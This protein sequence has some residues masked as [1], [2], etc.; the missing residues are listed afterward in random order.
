MI[1]FYLFALFA[2]SVFHVLYK[3][4]LSFLLLAFVIALPFVF[5]IILAI[6][7][8][9]LKISVFCESPV[10][11]RGKAAAVKVKFHNRSFIPFAECII[12]LTY[13]VSALS[14]SV[15]PVSGKATVSL[16]G[17]CCD[18][19]TLSFLPEHCGTVTVRIKNVC[20]KDFM[21][22]TRVYRKIGTTVPITAL[23]RVFPLS[24]AMD[25]GS[26]YDAESCVFSKEKPGDDPSEI[27][28]LREYR[29][30]DRHNLIHWK[31]SSRVGGFIVKELSKPIGSRIMILA[32]TGGCKNADGADRILEAAAALSFSLAERGTAHTMAYPMTDGTLRR[33][34]CAEIN[35]EESFWQEFAELSRNIR[36]LDTKL[37]AAYS[38]KLPGSG[39]SRVAAVSEKSGGAYAE[40]LSVLFGEARLTI[41]CTSPAPETDGREELFSAEVIYADAE[42]L[43]TGNEDFFV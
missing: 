39:F 35:G 1:V 13:T 42:K 22:I 23:P 6:N 18:T 36:T 40:Q 2:L 20:L 10:T 32:D 31:L 34:R 30:G 21:G 4:D 16:A 15:A 26:A 5:F 11:E 7:S 27:F 37:G 9:F 8:A 38:E 24:A 14:E 41:V 12:N 25:G 19:V 43:S 29:D 3:G 17:G 33:L 28:M